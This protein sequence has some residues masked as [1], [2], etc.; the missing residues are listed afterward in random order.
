MSSLSPARHA[1]VS[2]A[3]PMPRRPGP[4]PR[5]HARPAVPGPRPRVPPTPQ[6]P[7]DAATGPPRDRRRPDKHRQRT[8]PSSPTSNHSHRLVLPLPVPP[9]CY[10]GA[11]SVEKKPHATTAPP[12]RVLSSLF[13]PIPSSAPK[14]WPPTPRKLAVDRSR[15]EQIADHRSLRLI[16]LH[17][18]L[19]GIDARSPQSTPPR[20][21]SPTPT[22]LRRARAA[23]VLHLRPRRR[24]A[25]NEGELAVP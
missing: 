7:L 22:R 1:A 14:P 18:P 12:A 4:P 23:A 20:S 16:C 17:L 5:R 21:S 9:S 8:P 6:Q 13:L 3:T 25:R 2:P 11:P 10:K 19:Q 15:P 24:F